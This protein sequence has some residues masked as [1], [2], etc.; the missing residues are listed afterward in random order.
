MLYA[1]WDYAGMRVGTRRLGT[2]RLCLSPSLLSLGR[3]LL[4]ICA[5]SRSWVSCDHVTGAA[6]CSYS[7]LHTCCCSPAR[8]AHALLD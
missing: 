7:S 1:T 4:P 6:S 8:L 2:M 5:F 3:L